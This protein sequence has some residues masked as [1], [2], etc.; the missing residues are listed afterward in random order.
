[1]LNLVLFWTTLD[2]EC[3]YLRNEWR[4]PKSENLF[5]DSDSSCVKWKKFGKLWPTNQS[6]YAANVYLRNQLFRKTINL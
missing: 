4:Y 5:I 3:K 1:M 2:F 6:V